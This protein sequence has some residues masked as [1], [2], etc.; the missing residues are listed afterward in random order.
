M[1]RITDL[2]TGNAILVARS[3]DGLPLHGTIGVVPLTGKTPYFIQTTTSQMRAEVQGMAYIDPF[4]NKLVNPAPSVRMVP[5]HI[6]PVSEIVKVPGFRSLTREQMTAIIQDVDGKLGNIQPLPASLNMS[7]GNRGA[8]TSNGP[9][10]TYGKSQEVHPQYQVH[11]T[12]KQTEIR[13]KIENQIR[14]LIEENRK[15]TGR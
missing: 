15:A 1:D 10:A 6:F 3:A 2:A 4:T 9:W 5:D 13:D 11:L 7:K 14:V 12:R 8:G